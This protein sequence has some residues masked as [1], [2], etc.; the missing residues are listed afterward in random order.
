MEKQLDSKKYNK[1]Q[2][3]SDRFSGNFRRV[4]QILG[5]KRIRVKMI[6]G[7]QTFSSR[8]FIMINEIVSLKDI[9]L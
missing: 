1:M 6:M 5:S 2:Q 4:Y 3:S 7:N 8:W 9:N